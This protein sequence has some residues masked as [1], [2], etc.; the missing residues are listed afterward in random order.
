MGAYGRFLIFLAIIRKSVFNEYVI[1]ELEY[2]LFGRFECCG[3]DKTE[4]RSIFI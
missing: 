4:L 3:N 1:A 2:P